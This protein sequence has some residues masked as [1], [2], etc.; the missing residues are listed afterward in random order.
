MSVR[1][2][3]LA[4]E[5][6]DKRAFAVLSTVNP[7]GSPHSSVMWATYEDDDVLFSTIRGR[8]EVGIRDRH[9]R[10]STLMD[11]RADACRYVEIRGTVRMT[12]EGGD[13]LTDRLRRAYQGVPWPQRT[14]EIRLVCRLRPTRAVVL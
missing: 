6:L 12:E 1:L 2:P 11:E 10:V 14:G 4:R 8:R 13:A 9:P 7:D 3:D 5:L